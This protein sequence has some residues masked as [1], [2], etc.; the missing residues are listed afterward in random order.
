M[1]EHN[2]DFYSHTTLKSYNLNE[3]MRYQ[4]NLLDS[5]DV[6]TRKHSEHVADITCKLCMQM[7]LSKAF[8]SYCTYCAFLHDI[9]KL[10]IPSKILQKQ[11]KLTDEEYEVIKTH[12]TIGYKMCLKDPKLYPYKNRYFIPS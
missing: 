4:L 5:I 1:L 9:G 2:F 8:T 11:G 10:F 7:H 6:V 12:T 3:S